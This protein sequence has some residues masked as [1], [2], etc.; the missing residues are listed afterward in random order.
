MVLARPGRPYD[1]IFASL[2]SVI[3]GLVSL[4]APRTPGLWLPSL[5]SVFFLPG[6]C[7]LSGMAPGKWFFDKG[8][9]SNTVS[10]LERVMVSIVLSIFFVALISTVLS[11]SDWGLTTASAVLEVS[12]ITV[13]ASIIGMVRRSR[14]P[15]REQ[16]NASID[17]RNPFKGLN[18]WEGGITMLVAIIL[19][20]STTLALMANTSST[21]PY[22]QLTITGAS[23]T[24]SDLP[25]TAAVDQNLTVRVV[26]LNKMDKDMVYNLTVGVNGS[27]GFSS[28]QPLDWFSTNTFAAGMGFVSNITIVNGYSY[29]ANLVFRMPS[30]GTNKLLFLLNGE[31]VHRDVWLFLTVT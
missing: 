14:L 26:I 30:P 27:Q 25:L 4:L 7:V 15:A 10:T 24:L 20:A 9:G 16:F 6:Y 2:L 21:E 29:S 5:I 22:A 17:I 28:F 31:D 23:G 12:G 18:N 1:L 19:V 13:S 8:S 3:C 11:W